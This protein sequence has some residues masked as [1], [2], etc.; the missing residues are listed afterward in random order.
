MQKID[1][2]PPGLQQQVEDFVDYLRSKRPLSRPGTLRQDWGGG[3]SDLRDDYTAL[4]LQ[5]KALEWRG[6]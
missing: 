2:L 1:A 4:E 5:K 3:L 6:D